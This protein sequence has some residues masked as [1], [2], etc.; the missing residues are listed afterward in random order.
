MILG[1]YLEIEYEFLDTCKRLQ[2]HTLVGCKL[3][4]DQDLFDNGYLVRLVDRLFDKGFIVL[5]HLSS[6]GHR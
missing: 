2:E 6:T 4:I 3:L 5:Y 1:V